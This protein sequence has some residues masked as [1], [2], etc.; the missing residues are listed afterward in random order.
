MGMPTMAQNLYI[1][2]ET[3]KANNLLKKS[4]D[5]I[6]KEIGYLADVSKSKD[7]LVGT[8]NIQIGLMYGLKPMADVA[9]QYKQIK[10]AD[11]L[12]KQYE[13][14]YDRFAQFFG[15]AQGR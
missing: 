5:Y 6:Q 11:D 10:L 1:L 8:Q 4:A 9:A 7:Q 3:E 14:L 13:G 12:K 2:G 15:P